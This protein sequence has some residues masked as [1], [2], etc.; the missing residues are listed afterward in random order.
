MPKKDE[1]VIYANKEV[2]GTCELGRRKVI[3]KE[4]RKQ[5]ELIVSKI[6]KV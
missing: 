3:V 4:Q 6:R 1:V 5:T 2:V